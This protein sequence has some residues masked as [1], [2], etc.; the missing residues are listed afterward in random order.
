MI[1]VV[2]AGLVLFAVF[3]PAYS[4]WN[5]IVRYGLRVSTLVVVAIGFAAY[6]RCRRTGGTWDA[7]LMTSMA[8]GTAGLVMITSLHG[9]PFG[10]LGIQGDQ[11][12]RTEYVTRFADSWHL[13]DY[14]YANR[15]SYY[16]P[17]YFWVL[18]RA[19]DIAN[20]PAWHMIKFGQI[21]GV[22]ITP[23]IAYVLWRRHVDARMAALIAVAQMVLLDFYEPYEYLAI[24][25]IVPWIIEVMYGPLRKG[26]T[27]R[28]P[29]VLGLIG[30]IIFCTY[31]YW[32][33]V[34]PFVLL[35]HY[36]GARLMRQRPW[37]EIRRA[38]VALAIAAAGSSVFWAPLLWNF[39]TANQF[40]SLNNRW[41]LLDHG[42]LLLPMIEPDVYGLMNLVGLVYLVVSART[43]VLSRALL[44]IFVACYVF[45]IAG[46]F[47]VAVDEPVM[48][49]RMRL[50]SP[51]ILLTAS[52]LGLLELARLAMA[53][54]DRQRTQ[55]AALA[56]T[57]LLAV[58][59]LDRNISAIGDHPYMK[60][61]QNEPLPS[62]T[63]SAYHDP[64]AKPADVPADQLSAFIDARLPAGRHPVVFSDRIDL[65]AFYPYYGFVE[66]DFSYSHPTAEFENR[67]AFLRALS[68]ASPS[69]FAAR[70]ADNPYDHIDAIVLHVDG[71]QLEYRF[72]DLH[73]PSGTAHTR[74]TFA[75]DVL[76]PA[77]FDITQM[78]D[79]VVA[80]RRPSAGN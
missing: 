14:F 15:P 72:A 32:F 36:V 27:K 3:A 40:Y 46:F 24:V 43:R 44:V 9:T 5:P 8:V 50:L 63:L 10:A 70:T 39:L 51:F 71:N 26:A 47:L 6:L 59:V 64:D 49:F 53:R 41:L 38:W 34:V 68:N 30:S 29:I 18:G 79:Y 35:I 66:Y 58:Y 4:P 11:S 2:V 42:D 23:L 22:L 56:L 80:A 16:A 55:T 7:D 25:A 54:L 65:Y 28:N 37:A 48:A 76:D 17:L 61:A 78:G 60:G 31:Y 13:S 52:V 12:F 77:Y 75:R 45:H 69:E 57:A 20:V 33:F 21:A 1:S 73:W 19:A 67:L 62:G 74:L